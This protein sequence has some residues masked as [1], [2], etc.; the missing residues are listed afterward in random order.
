VAAPR[1]GTRTCW[2]AVLI[3]AVAI[4]VCVG[5]GTAWAQAPA[6]PREAIE[7]VIRDYLLNHPEV[8]VESLRRAEQ[9]RR[10]ATRAQARMAVQAHRQEL[11]RSPDSPVGGNP[12]GDVTVVE[13]FDY[14]CPHCRRMA[15]VIKTLLAE[16]GGV[17]LVYKEMPILGEESVLAARAA[18]AARAQGQY[19]GA[20]ERLMAEAGPFTREGLVATL[21]AIGLDGNR[22]RA[23]MDAPEIATLITRELALARALGIDGTP[24]FVVGAELVVGAVDLGTLRDLV[25]KA[26]RAP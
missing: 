18:L 17:R 5:G 20:H 7:Q 19:A 25:G 16:D 21:A 14:R 2:A 23:D 13:F 22:L 8:I 11:L 12:A 6:V 9:Q 4:A 10:E 26:R 3:A 15:S 1:C 24:A